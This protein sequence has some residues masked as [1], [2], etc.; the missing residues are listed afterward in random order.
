MNCGL[1]FFLTYNFYPGFGNSTICWHYICSTGP[2]K[3][4]SGIQLGT[5]IDWPHCHDYG[6]YFW[7]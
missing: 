2:Q 7:C 3:H 5:I 1:E 4:W 6:N